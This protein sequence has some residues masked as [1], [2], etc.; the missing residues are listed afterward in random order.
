MSYSLEFILDIDWLTYIVLTLVLLVF[1]SLGVVL[2]I[3]AKRGARA[4]PHYNMANTGKY[5]KE[6]IQKKKEEK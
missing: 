5:F 4:N 6:T 3:C 1:V 2:V